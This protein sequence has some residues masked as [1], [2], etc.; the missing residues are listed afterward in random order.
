MRWKTVIY[1][2]KHLQDIYKKV[3]VFDS[4]DLSTSLAT[5]AAAAAMA[6]ASLPFTLSSILN[7]PGMAALPMMSHLKMFQ[8]PVLFAQAIESA[9]KVSLNFACS[10]INRN[11]AIFRQ[12]YP[13]LP[14]TDLF[15]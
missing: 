11:S 15:S 13:V 2:R 4:Q 12:A 1:P 8:S 9:T 6:A 10:L 14:S 7:L 3:S 5:Q